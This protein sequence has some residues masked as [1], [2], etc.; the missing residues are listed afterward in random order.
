[1]PE[2]HTIHRYARSHTADLAGRTIAV[3]SPQGR[4]TEGA[5]LLDGRRLD[6][7][8][9][10]GKHLFYR[11]DDGH[12]L[13][14]H[15]GLFGKFRTH[16]SNGGPP[17]EPTEGTRLAL[18]TDDLTVYLAGPTACDL[19]TP[20][21]EDA[22]VARLGPDPLRPRASFD[23]FSEAVARRKTSIG[24]VLLD[25]SVIAG[26]GNVYRSEVP[27]L[28]GID[29]RRPANAVDPHERRLLWDL[30]G[31][32]LRRGLKSGRIVTVDPADVG[33]TRRSQLRN[34]NRVYVYKRHGE[35]C[36]RCQTPI[37]RVVLANRKAWWCPSCQ[38][39]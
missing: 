12:V 24:A 39:G 17:P 9:A 21:E 23:R 13:H 8:E 16:R 3:S 25:Q 33:L 29:P 20:D 35:P 14:V 22:I 34:H 28:A 38:P 27:F 10:V 32:E 30:T 36:H 26:I 31:Q 18:R 1:M 2:G 19:I 37:Q 11:W 4:F 7:I 5:R 6:E 15:L